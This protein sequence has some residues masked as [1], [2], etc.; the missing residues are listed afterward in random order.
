[1]I[2]TRFGESEL[3]A[4][5]AYGACAAGRIFWFYGGTQITKSALR[6]SGT[7]KFPNDDRIVAPIARLE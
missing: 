3:R 1:M 2:L 6:A 5:G 4:G 7:P